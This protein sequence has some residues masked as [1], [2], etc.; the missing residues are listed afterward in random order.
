MIF[1]DCKFNCHK[2]CEDLVPRDC[3]G[4]VKYIPP[5]NS[6]S[7]LLQIQFIFDFTIYCH[8]L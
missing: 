6:N 8:L 4:E 5:G 1:S 7:K 3:Q 2:K